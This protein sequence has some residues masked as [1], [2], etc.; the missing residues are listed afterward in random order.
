MEPI[1]KLMDE[2]QVIL[3]G[4]DIL[5]EAITFLNDGQNV[6]PEKFRKLIDFIRNYADKYHHAKEEDILFVKMR[7]SGFPV[8]GGPIEVM[9]VEH[10]QGREHIKGLEAGVELLEQGDGQGKNKIIENS[11][12]YAALLRSHIHKEDNILYPMAVNSLGQ[13]VI[14]TMIP[15]FEKV[16]QA[17]AGVEE[18]YIKLLDGFDSE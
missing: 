1:K 10:D 3:R 6:P 4:I 18:K 13:D 7:D 12:S 17:Q 8:N 11:V 14:N 2:H 16:E 9:L 5:E 15:D